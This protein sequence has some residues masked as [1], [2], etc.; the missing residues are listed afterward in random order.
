MIWA[1]MLQPVTAY[2]TPAAIDKIPKDILLLDFI[3]YFHLDKDIEDYLLSKGFKVGLGNLYSS[4]YP[5]Y[6]SRIEKD[7]VVGAQTSTWVATSENDIVREGKMYD[8]LY[9]AQMM[10]SSD[11]THHARYS[12]DKIISAMMPALRENLKNVKYPSLMQD[13]TELLLVDKNDCGG[14]YQIH[15]Q[16]E[17]LI[18]EHA[19]SEKLARIPW[20]ELDEI[21]VYVVTYSD[22][23]TVSIPV[24]YAG[25]INYWKR[26]KNEPFQATYYRHNGYCASSYYTDGI[27]KRIDRQ[28]FMT[29]YRYEWINP[30]PEMVI[31]RIEYVSNKKFATNVYVSRILGIRR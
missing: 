19:A 11:Y 20:K 1:D 21:G 10:W 31:E 8:L 3:W 16:V 30:R 5:R 27:E 28:D 22:G 4:H 29:I 9:T 12:Y 13:K 14:S 15:Q 26:R 23:S 18:F 17:S 24:T 6:E 7:G 25:N 2:K